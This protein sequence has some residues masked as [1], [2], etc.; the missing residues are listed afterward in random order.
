MKINKIKKTTL[1]I[2]VILLIIGLVF[3]ALITI[4]KN[5]KSPTLPI[6]ASSTSKNKIV[7]TPDCP[8]ETA[9]EEVRGTSMEPLI[10][11]GDMVIVYKGYEKCNEFKKGDLVIYKFA[12]HDTPLIKM[13]RAV[14]GDKFELKENEQKNWNIYINN[15]ILK[16]SQNQAYELN[17]NTYKMLKN[18]AT[19][20]PTI[21]T[22]TYLILGEETGGSIDST[23][24]GLVGKSGIIGL[25]E[26]KK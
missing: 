7:S 3:L 19:D 9:E 16:N 10:K 26:I 18:Y 6:T 1:F 21:P 4:L 8:I 12:G 25:A 15:E 17:E 14:S 13:V 20:Y 23:K 5:Q 24:F 22:D 11:N 2:L